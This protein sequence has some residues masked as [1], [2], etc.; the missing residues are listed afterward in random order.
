[1]QTTHS[2]S[3]PDLSIASPVSP[4]RIRAST[5]SAPI[6]PVPEARSIA[7]SPG[8]HGGTSGGDI[9]ESTEDHNESLNAD[10]ARP[11]PEVQQPETLEQLPIEI[12]SLTERYGGSDA[13][14]ECVLC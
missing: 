5:V 10:P 2:F 12:Q 3:R 9:F 13:R 1:V 4:S 6:V 14:F 8:K 11:T 7:F